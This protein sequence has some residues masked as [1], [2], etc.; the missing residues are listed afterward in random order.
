MAIS[1]AQSKLTILY[2]HSKTHTYIEHLCRFRQSGTQPCAPDCL[3][4]AEC[5]SWRAPGARRAVFHFYDTFPKKGSTLHFEVW[6]S[7]SEVFP[8]IFSVFVDVPLF[9]I[10]IMIGRLV[11][12]ERECIIGVDVIDFDTIPVHIWRIANVWINVICWRVPT[13][14]TGSA[15]DTR[16]HVYL[17]QKG[18]S[19]DAE[20]TASPY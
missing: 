1:R 9:E 14:K 18:R 19:N 11:W 6:A 16:R 2:K 5:E 20:W 17:S 8:S 15:F 12:W 7:I 3:K 10:E 13:P 4:L